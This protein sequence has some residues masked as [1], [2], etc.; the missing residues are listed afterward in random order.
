MKQATTPKQELITKIFHVNSFVILFSYIFLLMWQ[1]KVLIECF[2]SN[3]SDEIKRTIFQK[4][5]PTKM[6]QIL[7]FIISN[8]T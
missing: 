1:S 2:S 3:L 4:L 8:L 7:L 6:F 5:D